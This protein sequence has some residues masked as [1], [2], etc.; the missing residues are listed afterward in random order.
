MIDR[1]YTE[2][3][4]VKRQTKKT[5]VDGNK[6]S[7]FETVGTITGHLQQA[8]AELAES[9]AMDLTKSFSLWCAVGADVEA[10]DSLTIDSASYSVRAVQEN[11]VGGN[12]HLELVIEKNED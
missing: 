9:L 5:D 2:T 7:E 3:V 6:Y 10:G 11:S 12:Q 8:R 1:F 4:T